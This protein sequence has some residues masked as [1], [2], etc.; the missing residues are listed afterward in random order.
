MTD[1]CVRAVAELRD[2]GGETSEAIGGKEGTGHDRVQASTYKGER[3]VR[4]DDQLLLID[5]N[6]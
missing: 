6:S 1:A 4:G 2:K 5:K 3:A